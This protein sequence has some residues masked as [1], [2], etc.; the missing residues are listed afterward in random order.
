MTSRHAAI[1]LAVLI[2]APALALAQTEEGDGRDRGAGRHAP[3][4][5]A[6]APE[7]IRVTREMYAHGFF[8]EAQIGAIGF[9]GGIGEYVNV[10]PWATVGFGYEIFD[11]LHVM[12][13]AEG[14]MHDTNAPPPPAPTSFELVGGTAT[15]RLQA[16]FTESFA[17]YLS[18]Q[19]GVLVATT[20][21]LDLYGFQDASTVGVSYGGQLGADWHLRARHHLARPARGR[22]AL[23]VAR[24]GGRELARARHPRQRL[25]A[26][27]VLSEDLARGALACLDRAVEVADVRGGGL[28]AGPVDAAARLAQGPRARG[29][30]AGRHEAHVAAEAVGLGDPVPD[31][32]RRW[33]ARHRRRRGARARRGRRSCALRDRGPTT[34][35]R[36]C[37]GGRPRGPPASRR[38]RS[39]RRRA[40]PGRRRTRPHRSG[41]ARARTRARRPRCT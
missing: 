29:H 19:L 30:H 7:A 14:S 13:S 23:P 39:R 11:F 41:R 20:E 38:A 22:A 35:A 33:A 8:V 37:R 12:I 26:L 32:R 21:I 25:P 27:R 34:R 4:R 2:G 40:A 15:L 10:G 16:N 6:T 5:R 31:R 24:V 36:C 28:G 9:I 18:G 1:A 17:M 3:R